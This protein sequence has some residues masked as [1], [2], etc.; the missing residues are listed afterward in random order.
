MGNKSLTS[1]NK[2]EDRP[3]NGGVQVIVRAASILR[4]L[5]GHPEGLSLSQIAKTTAKHFGVSVAD[6][7]GASR[8]RAIVTARNVAMYLA[9]TMTEKSLDHIGGYFGN[10]DHTTVSHGCQR[11]EQ[12]LQTEPAIGDTLSEL[13]A[14]LLLRA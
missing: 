4:A 13:Q 9:R 2:R 14:R 10:R 1:S 3:A 6:L 11:V 12:Q 7:R 8:R 5:K